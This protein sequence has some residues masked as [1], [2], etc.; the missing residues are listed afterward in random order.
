MKCLVT[1]GA[2]FIGSHL[3][4]KLLEEGAEVRVLDDLSTGHIE[5]IE[6]VLKDIEFIE[7]TITDPDVCQSAC[8]GMDAV[9]HQAA[10]SSVP[11]SVKA[12]LPSH[13][14][15]ATG[16]LNMLIGARDA[17]VG[18]FVCACSSSAYGDTD[19]L[20]KVETMPLRPLSPYA[21]QKAL[22]E[23]YCNN[24]ANLYGLKTV[25]LRYFNIFGPRQDPNSP[26]G[27][28]IPKFA[29]ALL[30]NRRPIIFGD[31][32]QTRDFTYVDNAVSANLLAAK[33]PSSVAGR[34]YNVA[35]GTRFSL[36]YL[37]QEM[38]KRLGTDLE[39][40]FQE[41][42]A[43]DVRDSQA[44]INRAKTELGFDVIVQFEEGLDVT[45]EWYRNS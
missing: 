20:P 26:Y 16:T 29:S 45:V 43:G 30:D 6:P 33:A 22:G 1:G 12:P 17:E 24:F 34:I 18:S 21:S 44:D 10:I 7:D 4:R 23:L 40:E 31:G 11:R 9:F 39:P 15:N 28:V 32:E 25:G 5:N 19:V 36:L 35:C 37:L 3:I 2:G 8:K 41:T 14:A 27:G 38:Q 13:H 42:R